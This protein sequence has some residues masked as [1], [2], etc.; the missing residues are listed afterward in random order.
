MTRPKSRTDAVALPSLPWG[1]WAMMLL[2][3]AALL[4]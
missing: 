2:I 4:V 1:E 3:G